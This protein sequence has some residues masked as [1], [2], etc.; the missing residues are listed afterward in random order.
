[1]IRYFSGTGDNMGVVSAINTST[2]EGLCSRLAHP[3]PVG[4]SREKYQALDAKAQMLAKRVAYIVPCTFQSSPSKRQTGFAEKCNLLCLDIDGKEDRTEA[5]RVLDA[6]F[7][8]LGQ[9]GF[10]AW[11]TASS[12]PEHPRIR[13]VVHAE[14][15][16]LNLYPQAVRTVAEMLGLTQVNKESLI[17]VQPMFWP[18]AF[19]GD[20]VSPIIAQEPEGDP[21]MTM[22]VIG[23]ADASIATPGQK[24]NAS[25]DPDS[26]DLEY[27]R[28]P[29]DGITLADAEGALEHLDPDCTM[30]Q[31][32][33][34]AM[35]LKHQFG[36]DGYSLWDK[37]S[38]KGKK[39]VDSDE[40]EYRWSTL[41]AQPTD[42]AP[43]TIRSVFRQA[44]A[45]GWK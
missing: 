5:R 31:W 4:I 19:Q 9:L 7:G 1:M 13:V 16:P 45:R 12:T 39:Y 18:T 28:M 21:F 44:S 34:V 15:I 6:G 41:V 33:E 36:D 24:P 20:T 23:E 2:F 11:H 17:V 38:A 22:D 25:A 8:G 29:M 26:V 3:F 32:I 35:G 14:G 37:W 27:L 30:Q 43:T 10:I 40:T 42:R